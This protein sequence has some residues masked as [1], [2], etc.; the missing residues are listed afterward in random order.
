MVF[1]YAQYSPV[2][3]PYVAANPINT[4]YAKCNINTTSTTLA[5]QFAQRPGHATMARVT[6]T[7][8][9]STK[10]AFRIREYGITTSSCANQGD[11]YNPLLEKDA[12][13]RV[14]P[15]QDQ[16]RGRISDVTTAA[17]TV[18]GGKGTITDFLDNDV[19]VNLSGPD[20]IVGRGIS[21]YTVNTTTGVLTGPVSCC[22]IAYD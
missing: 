21:L 6:L 12:L 17:A 15:Y 1:P 10:Y 16:T 9:A 11:E 7:G 3:I 14:N 5:L 22:V 19:L 4:Q 20:S 2:R 18:V 13:N 8:T